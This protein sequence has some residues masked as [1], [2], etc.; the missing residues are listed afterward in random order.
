MTNPK[1]GT[2]N[3]T[4]RPSLRDRFPALGLLERK[5]GRRRL[6]VV[7]QT[8]GADCGAACLTTVL[9]YFGK[10]VGLEEVRIATATGRDGTSASHIVEAARRFD[11]RGRGVSITVDDLVYLETGAILHWGFNHFVVFEK[12]KRKH[13]AILDPASG[14]RNIT[15]EEF[16][17]KFTGVALIFSPSDSFAPGGGGTK[18]VWSYV[19]QILGH[20]NVMLRILVGSVMLQLFGLG[21]PVLTGSLV[22]RVIPRHDG[23]LLMVLAIALGCILVFHFFISM[24]RS[25]LLLQLRT[26]L[27]TQMT[28]NFLDHMM[29]LPYHFFQQRSSGDLMMRMNSNSTVRDIL[30][31]AALSGA[32]DGVLVITYLVVLFI[33]SPTMGVVALGLGLMRIAV[34]AFSRQRIRDLTSKALSKQALSQGYQVQMLAGVET[35]KASGTEARAIDRWSN[36]YVDVLNVSLTRGRL[37]AL[38]SS[39]SGG[40]SY[41]SPV[42]ILIVGGALVMDGRLSI[43][44][45]LALSALAA[46]FLGPLS[47]LVQTAMRLQELGSYIERIDDI[48]ETPPEQPA[49]EGKMV[50]GLGGRIAVEEVSF[51]YTPG[52]PMVLDKVSLAI[53]PGQM[54]AIVGRSGA[55]KS[56]LAKLLMALYPPDSGRLVYDQ[57]DLQSLDVRSLR[58]HLG[59]VMQHQYLF[60]VSIRDNISLSDPSITFADVKRA[61]E[62]AHI[63]DDIVTMPMGYDTVIADGGLSLSGG[64]RQRLTLARALVKSP[65]VLILD[66]AT[67]SLDTV[68]EK[69]IQKSLKELACTRVVIAHRLSTVMDADRIIVLE[70][71]RI[72]EQGTHKELSAKQGAYS[73]LLMGQLG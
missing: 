38:L 23:Q 44:T 26:Q 19:Q 65:A 40:L 36:L 11:L 32:L 22:D 21:L 6:P 1:N 58:Q 51:S 15:R 33:L 39:I 46:G 63:H 49:G 71:G 3:E 70:N 45:M 14:R 12:L 34:F 52:S 31:S 4:A 62:L 13:V 68:T 29:R 43:G 61:A 67:S 53:E 35:L 18:R 25:L 73:E 50:D 28:L 7:Q 48:L 24:I 57:D 5:P 41:A 66:E 27:D 16:A 47:A 69:L 9:R 56:T 10:H 37:D 72:V 60:G 42:L 17:E 64:Q 30:T 2:S 54:V 59:V 20:S 8:T 55:G